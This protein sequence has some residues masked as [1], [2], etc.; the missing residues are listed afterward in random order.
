MLH[1]LY[2]SVEWQQT[3]IQCKINKAF[4]VEIILRLK[5]FQLFSLFLVNFPPN[6]ILWTIKLKY[7]ELIFTILM[8]FIVPREKQFSSKSSFLIGFYNLS[9][10]KSSPIHISS[11]RA[12][13]I[14]WAS[15][16]ST[17]IIFQV[18]EK[19]NFLKII[20]EFANSKKMKIVCLVSF[21]AFF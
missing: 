13:D 2:F 3:M 15:Y 4:K 21:F 17:F 10:M 5:E 7:S 8:I 11:L 19:Y 6:S 9:A 12:L 1:V 14:F 20:H 16:R 18:M